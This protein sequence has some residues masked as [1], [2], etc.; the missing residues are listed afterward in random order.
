MA[1][2]YTFTIDGYDLEVTTKKR[3]FIVNLNG[4]LYKTYDLC[5][6]SKWVATV[7]DYPLTFGDKDY[8]LVIRGNKIRFVYNDKYLDNNEEFIPKAHLP[9]WI[10]IFYALNIAIPIISRGGF[11]N[12]FF[13]FFGV[14]ICSAIGS[15]SKKSTA[16]KVILCVVTTIGM[17]IGWIAVSVL[18]GYLFML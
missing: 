16:Q 17:Y 3:K 7:E 12:A 14:S 10:L 18:I 15:S 8:I 9:M 2:I 6:W 11:I 5:T 1:K 13:G 4:E